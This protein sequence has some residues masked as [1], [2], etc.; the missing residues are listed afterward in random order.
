MVVEPS[1]HLA[2]DEE[3]ESDQF[4]ELESDLSSPESDGAADYACEE[5]E[6]ASDEEFLPGH[7]SN[8]R[9]KQPLNRRTNPNYMQTKCLRRPT[10]N[11][12]RSPRQKTKIYKTKIATGSVETNRWEERSQKLTTT[13]I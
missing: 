7:T 11:R 12:G 8:K 5:V 2:E 4:Q 1:K 9:K 10:G 3:L 6:S 13:H